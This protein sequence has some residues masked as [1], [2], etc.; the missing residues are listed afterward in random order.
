MAEIIKPPPD[1]DWT[2]EFVCQA[3]GCGATIRAHTAD[4]HVGSFDGNAWENGV[5]RFYVTCPVCG[6]NDFIKDPPPLAIRAAYAK[7]GSRFD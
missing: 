5:R 7:D 4:V 1:G 3:T 2:H 6:T